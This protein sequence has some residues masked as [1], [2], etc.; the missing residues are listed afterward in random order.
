MSSPG[1]P[2]KIYNK[3]MDLV[4]IGFIMRKKEHIFF[5]GKRCCTTLLCSLYSFIM[6]LT[7]QKHRRCYIVV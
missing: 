7:A 6:Q 5:K 4:S 3:I 1:K 2:D